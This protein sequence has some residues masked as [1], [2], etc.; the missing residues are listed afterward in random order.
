MLVAHQV[1]EDDIVSGFQDS[2]THGLSFQRIE[3]VTA[4][5]GER[6]QRAIIFIP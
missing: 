2:P 5:S 4:L 1:L 3:R 6:R